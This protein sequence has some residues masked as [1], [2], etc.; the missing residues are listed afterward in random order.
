MPFFYEKSQKK[1]LI[2]EENFVISKEMST[3]AP[4]KVENGLFFCLNNK[5][6][7][8]NEKNISTPQSQE[9]EQARFP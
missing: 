1:M 6:I 3:F 4:Q 5:I 2:F 8:K 9:S 7:N